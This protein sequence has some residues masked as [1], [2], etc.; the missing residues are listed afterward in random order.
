MAEFLST[1]SEIED[2]TVTIAAPYTL[3]DTL[4]KASLGNIRVAAQDVSVHAEGAYTGE[5]SAAQL[6]DAGAEAVI[7]GHSERRHHHQE[8]SELCNQKIRA[9]LNSGLEVI[10][11]VGETLGERAASATSAVITRQIEEGLNNFSAE[12]KENIV[13]AYEPVWAIG[14]GKTPTLQEIETVHGMI[15]LLVEED[16]P[17]VYGG[18]VTPENAFEILNT[19]NVNG[20]LVGGASLDPQSFTKII[21]SA[22]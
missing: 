10:Y 20:L 18:S 22:E 9:A 6:L 15:R 12:E 19:P 1:F 21:Q 13:I 8:T 3:I 5:V 17:I 4:G 11:C 7:V 14:T 2:T 16:T